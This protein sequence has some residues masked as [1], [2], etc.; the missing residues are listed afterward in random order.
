MT[1]TFN[2]GPYGLHDLVATIDRDTGII[3][4]DAGKT[5]TGSRNFDAFLADAG[6]A[7]GSD[8]ARDAH[9][10]LLAHG[11]PGSIPGI[12]IEVDVFESDQV[13]IEM[14]NGQFHLWLDDCSWGGPYTTLALAVNEANDQVGSEDDEF[15]SWAMECAWVDGPFGQIG[16]ND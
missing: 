11:H 6:F 8:E 12:Q 5:Y 16:H 1:N 7:I 10:E 3:T 13:R 4:S 15:R 14:H 9:S 2:L